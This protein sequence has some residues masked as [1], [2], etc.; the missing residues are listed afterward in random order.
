MLRV[1]CYAVTHRIATADGSFHN[2]FVFT[3]FVL[4][5]FS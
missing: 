3:S 4:D 1:T 5:H 2:L